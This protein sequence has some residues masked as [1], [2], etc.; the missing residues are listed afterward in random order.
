[1]PKILAIPINFLSEGVREKL[2]I[3]KLFILTRGASIHP[4]NYDS[5]CARGYRARAKSQFNLKMGSLVSAV[6]QEPLGLQ[7]CSKTYSTLH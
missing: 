6:A 5:T 3:Q 2:Q 1:M 4:T 7:A